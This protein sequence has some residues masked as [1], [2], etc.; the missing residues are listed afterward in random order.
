MALKLL[1]SPDAT[2]EITLNLL[3]HF[4]FISERLCQQNAV[5]LISICHINCRKHSNYSNYRYQGIIAY[6]CSRSHSLNF[7]RI[8]VLHLHGCFAVLCVQRYVRE[9]ILVKSGLH[10]STSRR[11][12]PHDFS[13]IYAV[14][15]TFFKIT[16]H[17]CLLSRIFYT[18][19]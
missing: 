8:F 3:L 1:S 10:A 4:R 9:F 6:S 19:I 14:E 7:F 12:F 11:C 17:V 13:C 16:I 18:E 5:Q 15:K 2:I